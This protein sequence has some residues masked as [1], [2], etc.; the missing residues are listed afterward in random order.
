MSKQ[1]E[2]FAFGPCWHN[3]FIL[4][5]LFLRSTS[6]QLRH[7]PPGPWLH[8]GLF[9]STA[10]ALGYFSSSFLG[11]FPIQFKHFPPCGWLHFELVFVACTLLTPKPWLYFFFISG[12]R[13]L[14]LTIAPS[15]KYGIWWIFWLSGTLKK[16]PSSVWRT[17]SL[18]I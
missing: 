18:T 12:F 16:R 1:W 4:V 5:Y 8:L 11:E 2:H 15:W 13:L 6:V 17:K 9:F 3:H 7:L 14:T 10:G